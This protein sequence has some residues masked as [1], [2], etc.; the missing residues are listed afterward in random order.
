MARI[1]IITPGHLS[2]N[3]RVVKEADALAAAGHSVHVI[4]CAYSAWGEA[5]DAE[6]ADRPW[7]REPPVRFGPRAPKGLRLRQ[8]ARRASLLALARSGAPLPLAGLAAAYHDAAPELS[9]RAAK[10]PADLY[11]AH[12]VAALPAAAAAARRRGARY[13]FDAEDFHP[14]DPPDRPEYAFERSLIS[15]I[16]AAVLPGC[17]YMTAAAPGIADAYAAEYA[18]SRPTVVLNVFPTA[19]AAP[20]ATPRGTAPGAPS[21][22]W[23]SQTIG[24]DRGLECAVR[25]IALSQAAPH[26]HLRGQ[27]SPAYAEALMT[28]A[29]AEGVADRLHLLEPAAPGDMVR[30]AADFDVGLVGETGVSRNRRIALTNK[31]FTYLLAGAPALMSDIPAHRAFAAETPGAVVLYPVD[32][33][34]A[35]AEALDALLLKPTA[36]AKAR[37]AAFELGRRRFNWDLEQR[38]L[39]AAVEAALA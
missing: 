13:G 30:L 4:A 7:V 35:L 2:T 3:P 9:R 6:F 20:A 33:A 23:F 21:L 1:C 31:Q 11:I 38:S 17:A 28:L 34:Q 22:Y 15:R 29:R 36:L 5:A 8:K 18:V 27:A 19:D 37:A 10:V 24:P 14:G 16:E 32:D 25:A 12:Y 39:V 26:L